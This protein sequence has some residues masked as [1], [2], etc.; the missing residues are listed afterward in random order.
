[1]S[2]TPK[3]A[4]HRLP[5]EIAITLVVASWLIPGLGF[6]VMKRRARA[7]VQ[8]LMV[9]VTFALGIALRGGVV[10][11]VGTGE[12]NLINYFTFVVQLGAGL[13]SLA[14]LGANLAGVQWLGGQL[15]HPYFELGTYYLIVAGAINYFA[16]C[17]F[18]DRLVHTHPRFRVQEGLEPAEE[19][20]EDA[21]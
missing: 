15:W 21:Q 1:M 2:A 5:P 4:P 20:P 19:S 16:V 8:F 10:W 14:S 17:N 13:L 9:V 12:F 7:A 11:P 18:Y 3:T 6:W